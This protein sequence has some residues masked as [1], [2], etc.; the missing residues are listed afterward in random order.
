MLLYSAFCNHAD[1][2]EFTEEKKVSLLGKRHGKGSDFARALREI[3]DCFEKLKKQEQVTSDNLT[4]ETV[5]TNENNSDESLTRS[6]NDEAA[7]TTIVQLSGGPTNDLISLTEAS[8]AAAAEDALH[9]EEMQLEEAH[10]NS[11]FTEI[12]VYSTRSKTDASQS[13][14]IG[15]Q[16]RISAR[17]LRSSSRVDVGRLQ[18]LILSPTN[19]HR[20]S[21]R[22]VRRSRRIIKSSDDSD[23]NNAN[24]PLFPPNGSVEESDSEIMTVGSD[25]DS[26]NNGSSVDSGCKPVEEQPCAEK[27]EE[28]SDRLDFQTNASINKKKRK[29]NRKRQRSD[30]VAI[31]DEVVSETE[32]LKTDCLSPS[33]NEKMSERCPKEDGDEHLPLSKRARVR[34]G[35]SSPVGDGEIKIPHEEVKS[36]DVSETS[37]QSYGPLNT[38]VHVS[39]DIREAIHI[40]RDS[41]ILPLLHDSPDRK[42]Y[43][44]ETRK[45]FVDGEAA[46]PPSKRLHRALEAM[47][48]NAA[49]HSQMASSCSPKVDTPNEGCSSSVKCS[50]LSTEEK[51]LIELGSGLVGHLSFGVSLSNISGSC[52]GLNMVVLKKHG[53]TVEVVLDSCKTSGVGS[54]YPELCRDS[55]EHA[56]CVGSKRLKLSPLKECPDSVYEHLNPDLPNIPEDL[57][58]VNCNGPCLISSTNSCKVKPLA[59]K[60]TA[61]R[62]D[63]NISLLNSDSL[64]LEEVSGDSLDIEKCEHINSADGGD[65]VQKTTHLSLSEKQRLN[66]ILLYFTL[67]IPCPIRS[68]YI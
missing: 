66:T 65:E 57:S 29:P 24:S 19:N 60:D 4:E 3:I 36:L 64:L 62:T 18:K 49:E 67:H 61:N 58:H 45:N 63:S 37:I 10:S 13:R 16:R 44:W 55:S 40:K 68:V 38:T 23:G 31:L 32:A 42:P 7:L 30:L 8:V 22:S 41:D 14:N 15:Q 51:S 39:S 50:E 17:K 33:N 21:R 26:L 47:C 35:K 43:Y 28:L 9:E 5:T 52:L 20:S 54:S 25:S 11:G 2:E 46:L 53:E 27:N 1:I 34:L 56:E 59:V 12:H 48:A 6:V